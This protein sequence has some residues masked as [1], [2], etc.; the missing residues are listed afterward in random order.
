MFFK[1]FR[2]PSEVKNALPWTPYLR[3]H[4]AIYMI[5]LPPDLLGECG[6]GVGL[7]LNLVNLARH[8]AG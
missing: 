6:G 2:I 8:P 1:K 4:L 3:A 7:D 5:D